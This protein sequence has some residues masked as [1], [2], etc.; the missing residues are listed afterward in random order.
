M[1]KVVCVPVRNIDK[2]NIYWFLVR[3]IKQL[4]PRQK[5]EKSPDL[6]QVWPLKSYLCYSCFQK[7][8]DQDE[9]EIQQV[10][11]SGGGIDYQQIIT[12]SQDFGNSCSSMTCKAT[13]KR[14]SPMSYGCLITLIQKLRMFPFSTQKI[15]IVFPNRKEKWHIH[16]S[17]SPYLY[18]ILHI[19]PWL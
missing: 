8:N 4:K 1:L 14:N 16:P 11:I 7:L 12:A 2:Y 15:R 18:Y 10:S 13:G 5:Q 3:K 9:H 19:E 6:T 17:S